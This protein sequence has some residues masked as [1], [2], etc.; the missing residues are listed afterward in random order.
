[1][2]AFTIFIQNSSLVDDHSTKYKRYI[3]MDDQTKYVQYLILDLDYHVPPGKF[4][5]TLFATHEK[6][7]ADEPHGHW[8]ITVVQSEFKTKLTY[9]IVECICS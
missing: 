7:E 4:L 8:R 9:H 2:N 6:V 3:D 5:Q 1:M